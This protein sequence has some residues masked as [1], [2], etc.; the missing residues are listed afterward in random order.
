MQKKVIELPGDKIVTIST[1]EHILPFDIDSKGKIGYQ[2][3][4]EQL[5]LELIVS[6]LVNGGGLIIRQFLPIKTEVRT[7]NGCLLFDLDH[8]ISKKCL[9][10]WYNV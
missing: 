3:Q 4:H 7:S 8:K 6:G 5:L 10:P 1:G 2:K 9:Y